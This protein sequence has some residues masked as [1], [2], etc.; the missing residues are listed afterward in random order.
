MKKT[1]LITGSSGL[2]GTELC[3][4]FIF[5]GHRVLGLDRRENPAFVHDDFTFLACD[6]SDE[7]SIRAAL[8]KVESV[9]TVINNAALTDLTAKKFSQ[10]TLEDWSAG[11]AVNLTSVFLIAQALMPKLAREKGSII[12]ISSSRHLMSEA[13]TEVYSAT[14]GALVS[15]THAMA[16]TQA[17]QVRV[18][19]ISPGWIAAPDDEKLGPKDHDQ[20]PAGRVG[21]PSDV[22]KL[23]FFLASDDAGFITGQDFVVDG[24]MTRKMIYT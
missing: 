7:K 16:I 4:E 9:H 6:L 1:A 22:A 21:K 24:G 3:R 19:C 8:S 12:N 23:A 2:I 20:H 11:I 10:L 17:H 18:N 15:L 14:K 13:N 5:Q